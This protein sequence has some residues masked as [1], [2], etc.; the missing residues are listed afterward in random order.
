MLHKDLN[1]NNMDSEIINE[2]SYILSKLTDLLQGQNFNNIIYIEF[3]EN[4]D[5]KDIILCYQKYLKLL[6]INTVYDNNLL[7][8]KTE[9]TKSYF[10][11]LNNL[12]ILLEKEWEKNLL[13]INLDTKPVFLKLMK[14]NKLKITKCV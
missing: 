2:R 9:I 6:K 8:L 12:I 4:S 10:M 7:L 11:E 1:N 5:L 13:N 14:Y 3:K